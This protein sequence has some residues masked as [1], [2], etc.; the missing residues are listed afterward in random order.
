MGWLRAKLFELAGLKGFSWEVVWMSAWTFDWVFRDVFAFLNCSYS[1][2]NFGKGWLGNGGNN[3][4]SNFASNPLFS[5]NFGGFRNCS[6]SDALS[7]TLTGERIFAE[8]SL[9]FHSF[10]FVFLLDDLSSIKCLSFLRCWSS[11]ESFWI[12]SA[13]SLT[14][15]LYEEFSNQL[16]KP[17]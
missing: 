11:S 15:I 16:P 7:I 3:L 13:I 1:V 5:F 14:A 9:F 4:D 6:Y 10:D 2:G 12:R 8:S 17:F